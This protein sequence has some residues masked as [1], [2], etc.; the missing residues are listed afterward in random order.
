MLPLQN[1]AGDSYAVVIYVIVV[2][3]LDFRT[4]LIRSNLRHVLQ[5]VAGKVKIP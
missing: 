4:H 3:K 2:Y 5:D 1:Y